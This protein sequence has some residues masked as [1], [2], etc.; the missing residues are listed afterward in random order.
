MIPKLSWFYSMLFRALIPS[1][2]I[3]FV[4]LSYFIIANTGLM[5]PAVEPETQKEPAK[6][7]ENK[8]Q[9]L[10]A[11]LDVKQQFFNRSVKLSGISKADKKAVVRAQLGGEIDKIYVERGQYVQVNDVIARIK[12]GSINLRLKQAQVQLQRAENDYQAQKKLAEQGFSSE[13]L[14]DNTLLAYNAAQSAYEDALLAQD[15]LEIKASI[16]GFVQELDVELGDFISAGF[17]VAQIV[18]NDQIKVEATVNQKVFSALELGMS[19]DILFATNQKLRGTITFISSVALNETRTFVVEFLVANP[20][21]QLVEGLGA[22]ITLDLPSEMGHYVP[23]S[24]LTL[25]AN[26]ALGIKAVEESRVVFYPITILEAD[27]FGVW[28]KGLP[29]SSNIIVK[30]QEFVSEGQSVKHQPLTAS[31][32]LQLAQYFNSIR[33]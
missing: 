16:D 30:G 2:F 7:E 17:G 15:N 6:L 28:V 4:T 31:D 24:S 13:S 26:S 20:Q 32:K 18:N 29:E 27:Q 10:T 14:L 8:D 25:S 19:A 3:I 21:R 9:I 1:A 11:T 22:S 5:G 33:P 12:E 23:T